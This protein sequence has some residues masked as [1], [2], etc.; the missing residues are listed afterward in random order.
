MKV[1]DIKNSNT[2]LNRVYWFVDI[3]A[4]TC[5]SSRPLHKKIVEIGGFLTSSRLEIIPNTTFN[6]VVS[7]GFSDNSSEKLNECSNILQLGHYTQIDFQILNQL[8]VSGLKQEKPTKT[9]KEVKDFIH[10]YLEPYKDYEIIIAGYSPNV[11]DIPL[12]NQVFPITAKWLSHQVLDITSV[13]KSFEIVLQSSLPGKPCVH[14]A[15]SDAQHSYHY[16]LNLYE[17]FG[18]Q[19]PDR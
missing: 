12:I 15:L 13:R 2:V 16:L 19:I 18:L 10:L 1:L 3:E 9:R 17:K 5:Y 7:A 4:V 14:R 6:H 11:L 8:E